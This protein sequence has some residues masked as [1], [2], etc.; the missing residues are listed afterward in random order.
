MAG[1]TSNSGV[2]EA[3]PQRQSKSET[4]R[5]NTVDRLFRRISRVAENGGKQA[6]IRGGLFGFMPTIHTPDV[7]QQV[8]DRLRS[9]D[10]GITVLRFESEAPLAIRDPS[11]GVAYGAGL[12]QVEDVAFF[13][14]FNQQD[15]EV[16]DF[17][18]HA[19]QI[20]PPVET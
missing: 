8:G 9:Q 15:F 16:P 11:D 10:I 20:Y 5:Q 13:T 17:G 3:M 19:T 18:D 14:R 2:L 6:G 7:Y 4:R 1:E 12:T